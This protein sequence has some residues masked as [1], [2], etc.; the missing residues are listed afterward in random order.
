MGGDGAASGSPCSGPEAASL[1]ACGAGWRARSG[2]ARRAGGDRAG[3][4]LAPS[5]G[6]RAARAPA[7]MPPW[8]TVY[9]WF[10]RWQLLNLFE[11]MMRDLARLRR[12]AVGRRPSPRPAITA[13]VGRT[14]AS[15]FKPFAEAASSGYPRTA[16]A[17]RQCFVCTKPHGV[18]AAVSGP[19]SA[20]PIVSVSLSWP[21]GDHGAWWMSCGCPTTRHRLQHS[22][23]AHTTVVRAVPDR[24]PTLPSRSACA[25]SAGATGRRRSGSGS[26][27]RPWNP[28]RLSRPWRTDT[29]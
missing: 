1:Q 20:R 6:W 7:G 28:A 8:H 14:F 2:G 3:H 26:C 22:Q 23:T 9:G 4:R 17:G 25:R 13:S 18:Q 24:G 29:G 21:C 5:G 15:N 10:R 11:R 19:V 12:R 27:G 16:P